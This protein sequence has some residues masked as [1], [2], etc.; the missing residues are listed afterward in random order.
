MVQE[1][2]PHHAHNV[3]L[4]PL[5]CMLARQLHLPPQAIAAFRIRAP[6]TTRWTVDIPLYSLQRAL[7]ASDVVWL[8]ET[9]AEGIEVG[10]GGGAVLVG[11][12]LHQASF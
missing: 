9:V 3:I 11:W 10:E 7:A 2:D 6:E 5:R 8:A 4:A 1:H 12:L